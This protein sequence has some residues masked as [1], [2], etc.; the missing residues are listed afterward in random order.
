MNQKEQN[1]VVGAM[2]VSMALGYLIRHW[3]VSPAT[4]ARYLGRGRR[5][6]LQ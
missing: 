5:G 6:A 4:F 3:G 2:V 1:L